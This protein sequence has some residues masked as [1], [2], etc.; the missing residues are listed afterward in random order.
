MLV[1]QWKVNSESTA[2]LMVDFYRDFH[3]KDGRCAGKKAR[4]LRE[5][6]LGLMKNVHY[7]HPYYWAGFVLVGSNGGHFP[8]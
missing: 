3:S 5:A 8:M 6:T 7:L 4:A 2:Q 1:S